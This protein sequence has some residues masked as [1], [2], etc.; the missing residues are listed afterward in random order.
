[1]AKAILE[2]GT[3]KKFIEELI[4]TFLLFFGLIILAGGVF[5]LVAPET[6]LDFR[7][8]TNPAW[9]KG[10]GAALIVIG[11]AVLIPGIIRLVKPPRS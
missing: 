11:C 10:G 2:G 6:I 1:M 7:P 9:M 8:D 3:M 5:C 4:T